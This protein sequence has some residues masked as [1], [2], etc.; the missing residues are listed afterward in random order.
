MLAALP[1]SKLPPPRTKPCKSVPVTCP[2]AHADKARAH[3]PFPL[4]SHSPHPSLACISPTAYP[5]VSHRFCKTQ[6]VFSASPPLFLPA[7]SHRHHFA[8]QQQDTA[9]QGSALATAAEDTKL[10]RPF[11][12]KNKPPSSTATQAGPHVPRGFAPEAAFPSPGEGLLSFGSVKQPRD[13]HSLSPLGRQHVYW[14]QNHLRAS[15][16]W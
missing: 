6:G 15:D 2:L 13:L 14:Q 1:C 5:A 7:H 4:F 8:V 11:A 16:K 3:S 12:I 10:P 9:Q